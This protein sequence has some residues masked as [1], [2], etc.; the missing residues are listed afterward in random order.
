MR[1]RA[2]NVAATKATKT[3]APNTLTAGT[4]EARNRRSTPRSRYPAMCTG[5]A[6]RPIEAVTRPT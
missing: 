6:I 1:T 2:L 4:A 3:C 5:R